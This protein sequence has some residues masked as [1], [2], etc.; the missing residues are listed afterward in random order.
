LLLKPVLLFTSM[1]LPKISFLSAFY[2]GFAVVEASYFTYST[3]QRGFFIQEQLVVNA[4]PPD[5]VGHRARNIVD[6]W[7]KI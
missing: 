4:N 2:I 6:I 7:T 5:Y 3:A 1:M